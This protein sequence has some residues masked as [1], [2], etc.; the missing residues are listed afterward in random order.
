MTSIENQREDEPC[1][2]EE[3]SKE[4]QKKCIKTHIEKPKPVNYYH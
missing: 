2:D 1:F 3:K 4:L